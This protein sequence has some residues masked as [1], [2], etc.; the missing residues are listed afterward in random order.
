MSKQQSEVPY[1]TLDLL[2]LKTLEAMGTLHGYALARRIEQVCGEDM[3]LSQGSVYPALIRL[4]QEGWIST[5]WGV[6]ETNREV[7]FYSLTPGGR[8]QLHVEVAK[9]ERATALVARFL[10]SSS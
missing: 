8:Q 4:Q 3:Q 6:S 7:K 10:E 1:G 9:W 2:I 5:D